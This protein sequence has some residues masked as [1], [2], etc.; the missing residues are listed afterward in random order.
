VPSICQ[1]I[2]NGIPG[3]YEYML[4]FDKTGIDDRNDNFS[5]VYTDKIFG[6]GAVAFVYDQHDIKRIPKLKSSLTQ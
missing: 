5:V 1:K 2:E 3:S 6:I 4:A